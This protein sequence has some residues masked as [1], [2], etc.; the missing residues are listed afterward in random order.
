MS[1]KTNMEIPVTIEALKE[2]VEHYR[3][4]G[5]R[6][7]LVATGGALHAGHLSLIPIARQHA[8]IVVLTCFVNPKEFGL[9]ERFERYP[10]QAIEDREA[11]ESAEVDV[12]FAPAAD[13]VYPEGFSSVIREERI[14]SDLCGD[15]RPHYFSGL[16]T[17]FSIWFNVIRPD[18][19]I[20]GQKDAQKNA[21]IRRLIKDFHWGIELVV[22]P[23]IR[24]ENGL[25][26][27]ARNQWF[28]PP[29]RDG[30][31]G[32]YESLKAGKELVE[33]GVRNPDRIMAEVIHQLSRKRR[34]RIIYVA[35][36]DGETMKPVREV[37][38]GKTIVAVAVWVDEVRVIDNIEL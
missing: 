12:F 36:V 6:I 21:A 24:E 28:T 1:Y 23:T 14:T 5:K 11:A 22:G 37:V 33:E 4:A 27:D 16:L 19:L 29:Q 3:K 30:A 25:A 15:S 20:S 17:L 38:P 10:R 7:A 9:H 26:M 13:E 8:D 18:V 32:I 2:C 34:I 35:I 31:A